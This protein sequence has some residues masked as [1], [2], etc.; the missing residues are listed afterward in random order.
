MTKPHILLYTDNPPVGGVPR[1]NHSLLCKLATSGY[2]VSAVQIEQSNP[3]VDEQKELGIRQLW[4]DQLLTTGYSGSYTDWDTPR[5]LISSSKPDLI[6]FSDGWPL[7]N[8]AAKQVALQMEIP[9]IIVVG[10]VAPSSAEVVR[11]DGVP[12]TEAAAYH[13]A[14][15]KEVVAVSQENLELLHT[16]FKLPED[17]GQVIHYGRPK[18]FFTPTDAVTRQHLRQEIGVPNDAV[19]CFTSARMAAV[20]GFEFQLDAIEQLKRTPI[21]KKLYFV[22]AGTGS[23]GEDIRP[24]LMERILLLEVEDRVKFLGK[25]WDI[26]DL[27]G[28][29]DI[30][31][32]SSK[33][34]GMP[35]AIMEA[36][37]KGLPVMASA[38]SGIPE[39][40]GDTGK[41]LPDP[42]VDVEATVTELVSSIEAW[43]TNTELRK[44]AGQACQQR[45]KLM[46]QEERMLQ[47]YLEVIEQVLQSVELDRKPSSSLEN[48]DL[49]D[50]REIENRIFYAH[51]VWRAWS[52]HIVGDF[53]SMEQSLQKSLQHTPFLSTETLINWVGS[54]SKF[55]REKGDKFDAYALCKLAE[56]RSL[57]QNHIYAKK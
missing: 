3:L 10:F 37:A 12:Y 56:W 27:L 9:Y 8:F 48:F 49:E 28:A 21:W 4:L 20:K 52:S 31:I 17:R 14:Q 2:Q 18:E 22:W 36:M 38:V 15:A 51:L 25:R 40:L 53:N 45:A 55:S 47:D 7:G 35:L 43:A 11:D 32:L 16:V 24:Q 29:S 26:P 23:P 6:I 33:A 46:F 41:L 30:Y 39:E 50:V 57:T 1:Y 54:F 5:K 34:E 42:N 44:A 13:Y 19:M